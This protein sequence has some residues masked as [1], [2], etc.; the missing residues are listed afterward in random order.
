MTDRAGTDGARINAAGIDGVRIDGA[1]LAARAVLTRTL[2]D[3]FETAGYVE[4]Q[5]PTLDAEVC[6]DAHIDPVRVG[7]RFLQPSPEL[8]MKRLLA[9]PSVA[10]A[11][12]AIWQLGPAFRFGERGSWHR[13]EFIMC[14]WY[15]LG[16]DQHDQMTWTESLVDAV[17]S[18]A[19]SRSGE[20]SRS[21]EACRSPAPPRPYVRVRYWDAVA[22]V[23]GERM[24]QAPTDTLRQRVAAELGQPVGGDRDAILNLL[25]ATR[26]EP[27]LAQ[28]G[29]CFLLDYPASQAALARVRD[30]ADHGPVAERFELYVAH[31][32]QAI[33][34]ANGYHELADA[35]EARRRF[36]A[37]NAERADPLP[38]PE[39]FLA[40][41]GALPPCSGV[42]LGWDRL[43]AVALGAGGIEEVSVAAAR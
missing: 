6:V 35:A 38:L 21:S 26:I 13:T 9:D 15:R 23:L 36:E 24:E 42:A 14:E 17:L 8:A 18:S 10:A 37:A 16:D 7:E 39:A 27:S 19:A 29:A 3:T 31:R 20:A 2:R 28:H 30:D 25:M 5:T 1:T 33:E 11:C 40:T 34:L 32:G 41:A 4:V 12:P 43:I 22:D